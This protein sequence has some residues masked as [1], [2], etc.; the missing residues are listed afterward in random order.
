VAIC[1]TARAEYGYAG[2]GVA[3]PWYPVGGIVNVRL[4]GPAQSLDECP[5]RKTRFFRILSS[6]AAKVPVDT[7]AE[8]N[9][10]QARRCG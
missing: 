4:A 6:R 7:D 9:W 10:R 5:A 2:D 8:D 3:V 1:P